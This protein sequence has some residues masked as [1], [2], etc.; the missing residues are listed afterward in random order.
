ME[1]DALL[2]IVCPG[3]NDGI[4]SALKHYNDENR[5]MFKFD[6]AD[7]EK[8][9]KLCEALFQVLDKG[10]QTSCQIMCLE[11]LRILSRDKKV[12]VPVTTKKNLQILMRMAKLDLQL[13]SLGEVKD[14]PVVVE[15]LKCLCNIVF[16]S[17]E[18]QKLSLELDLA[19]LLCGL[20][21][22]CKDQRMVNDIRC[23]ALRL[24]FLLTLLHTDI[25]ARLKQELQGLPL[26][27]QT[28]ESI[29]GIQWAEK[30]Q[31]V[32]EINLPPL[33]VQETDCTIEALKALFNVTL[34]SWNVHCESDAH[35]FR[36]LTAILRHVLLSKAPSADKT[37]EL[38]SNTVNLLS[39]V[40]VS[41]LD[42]LI[43]PFNKEMS[44]NNNDMDMEAIQVILNF[45]EKRIDKGCSYRE[46]LTPVLSLLTECSRAHRPIRKYIKAEVLPPLKD[47]SNRP[48]V[49]MTVRNKLVRLMTHVDLGVKQIAAEFLFVLCKE[50]VD[51]LLKY[52]G[53]GN[54]AGLLAA[55]GLLAGGRGDRWY[56]DDEDTDTEE[57]LLAKPNINLITGHVE[58]PL[59]NPMDEMTEEQKEYEAMKL[60][61][62]FDKLSREELIKPMGVKP[63]G[64]MA[65]L[66]ETLHSQRA[67]DS[68]SDSD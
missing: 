30:Y 36:Y 55:R 28:L 65:P 20:L 8:R 63:D 52:T 18:A 42:V 33:S 27:T 21:G 6:P 37:E 59:P 26:L 48:E 34:D 49:G 22:K 58:E 17:M 24:L 61:N 11:A 31:T 56:S 67:K 46:G 35:Q 68:S 32:T 44:A 38:H 39:N 64:T 4:E 40:P 2:E 62:M 14:F 57:Y 10:T 29:L 41:C 12:L 1:L 19:D 43:N 60:V 51:S 23:F 25:R 47:V 16:N 9:M 53:Y 50:R 7:V 3:Q 45:M 5:T 66:E 13:N 15:A 54:A